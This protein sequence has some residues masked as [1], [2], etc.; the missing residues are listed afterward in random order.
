MLAPHMQPFQSGRQRASLIEM[1]LSPSVLSP[2]SKGLRSP[3]HSE[4]EG[5]PRLFRGEQRQGGVREG[6]DR[7]DRIAL[8]GA[9]VRS[10][11]QE[12]TE[13]RLRDGAATVLD[14]PPLGI[15]RRGVGADDPDEVQD[16]ARDDG[17]A[18]PRGEDDR[19]LRELLSFRFACR[20]LRDAAGSVEAEEAT[21][22]CARRKRDRIPRGHFKIDCEWCEWFTWREWLTVD[23]R[24][25]LVETHNAPMPNARDFFFGLHD[26][27]YAIFSK[28]ANYENGAGGV[29]YAFVK[30][31]TDFFVNDTLYYKRSALAGAG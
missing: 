13:R 17:R 26:A 25:I 15:R 29:E 7:G 12:Q 4:A 31:S 2:Q 9:H 8:R 6:R 30:L 27:G 28:E 10:R 3:S 16:A 5:L 24:Q 22:S 23:M 21:A 19:H 18:G 14:V 1:P 20:V 11:G